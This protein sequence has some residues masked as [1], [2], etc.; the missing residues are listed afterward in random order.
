MHECM[1]DK[2]TFLSSLTSIFYEAS[3]MLNVVVAE[4]ISASL[5]LDVRLG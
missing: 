2:N 5:T 4:V 1:V 3:T